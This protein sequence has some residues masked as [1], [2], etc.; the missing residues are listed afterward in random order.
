[1]SITSLKRAGGAPDNKELVSASR[2]DNATLSGR[3]SLKSMN[4]PLQ[5]LSTA[6][7]GTG[8]RADDKMSGT[9][10]STGAGPM[11]LR[12]VA[13]SEA[14]EDMPEIGVAPPGVEETTCK[15]KQNKTS[16]SCTQLEQ[17]VR[18]YQ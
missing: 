16:K 13:N 12:G 2:C 10:L 15:I 7:A 4:S 6:L 8:G 9:A 14:R 11:L 18:L 1:M 5:I 3:S 17:L